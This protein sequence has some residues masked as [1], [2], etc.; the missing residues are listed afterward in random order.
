MQAYL[1]RRV[2]QSALTLVGMSVLVFVLTISDTRTEATD[3]SGAA[4]VEALRSAGHIISGHS[5]KHLSAAAGVACLVATLSRRRSI[6][7]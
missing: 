1:L 6:G 7:W 3:T 5:L 4:I 2:G